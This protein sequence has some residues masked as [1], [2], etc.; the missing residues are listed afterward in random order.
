M[1]FPVYA[2]AEDLAAAPW[3]TPTTAG[4]DR[5]LATASRLVRRAT[6]TA[7]Y[8]TDADHLPTDE[9]LREAMRQATCAQVATWLAVKVDPLAGGAQASAVL[10]A[11]KSLGSGSISYDTSAAGSVNAAQA[12]ADAATS[13]GMDAY[14]ILSEAGLVSSRPGAYR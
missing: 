11:S 13:L 3:S 12:K 2:T 5:L 9:D 10:T 1:P 8:H 14:L 4:V 6:M 7:I